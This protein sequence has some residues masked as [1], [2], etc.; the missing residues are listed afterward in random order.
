MLESKVVIGIQ[1]RTNSS[2][3]PAKVLL[4]LCG[5]PIVVLAS[6][7]VSVNSLYD[8]DVKVLTSLE[9]SDDTLS[10]V[11]EQHNIPFFRGD[12]NNVLQRYVDA[13]SNYD[14]DTIVVRLT[15]DNV[16]P[17]SNF[18]NEVITA[19]KQNKL[20][21]VC[22]NGDKS[23]LPYGLSVEVT[24][25]IHLRDAATHAT[26]KF[27]L[28]H[29]TPY[30]KRK[31]GNQYFDKYQKLELGYLRCTIDNFDDYT[32]MSNVLSEI[33]NPI[34]ISA[35]DIVDLLKLRHKN[36]RDSNRLVIGGAQLGL[37]YGI[38][39]AVGKPSMSDSHKM[40]SMALSFGVRFI[41]TARVYGN[42][43]SVIGDWLSKGRAQQVKV[44]TKL[45]PFNDIDINTNPNLAFSKVECSVLRSCK[46]LQV[47][48]LDVLMLHRAEHL[49]LVNGAIL[50]KLL[51]LQKE[52]LIN[53]I[54]V[55]VQ[56][57]QELE[58][59]LKYSCVTFIQLP[60]NLL[61]SRWDVVIPKIIKEKSERPLIVHVRSVF[62][63][64]LLLTKNQHL[65]EKAFVSDNKEILN[66]LELLVKVSNCN[67]VSDLCIRYVK[68]QEWVDALVL[69]C[70]SKEQLISNL[71]SI[72]QPKL[73]FLTL[74]EI[75]NI[76]P[77]NLKPET[78]NPALWIQ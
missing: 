5:M 58:L 29:V 35:W 16:V 74:N 47:S 53:E 25:L 18:I 6:K 55:S 21:Y 14:D 12:L 38:N 28:E 50:E 76:R 17:D 54:G 23:G 34:D 48:Y 39:N 40:L 36:Y 8:T 7:R 63:Q 61:D 9:S 27:D 30:V 52:G 32:Q 45:E 60:F 78:L 20:D 64:G 68:S 41:D 75:K 44:I 13:F 2:R 77:K 26:T 11:L 59:V 33:T 67:S 66:W 51:L 70:E 10:H 57:P 72:G 31:F 43:E 62:L 46:E 73:D 19:F 4:P 56:T 49:T 15:S 22:A 42:S 69:G 71:K 1:A 24:R 3:L 37:D 65:W